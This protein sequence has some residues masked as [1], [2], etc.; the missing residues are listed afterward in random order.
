MLI[1][2]NVAD[3]FPLRA[4]QY[5]LYTDDLSDTDTPLKR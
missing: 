3:F 2:S 4:C 5:I 1:V